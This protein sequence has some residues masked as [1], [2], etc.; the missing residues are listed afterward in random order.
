MSLL[1]ITNL[2]VAI[3][4]FNILQGVTLCVDA[5]EIVAVTGESGSG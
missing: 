5:G 3:H 2:S 4:W 1:S